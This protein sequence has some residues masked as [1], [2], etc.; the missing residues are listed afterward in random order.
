M[1]KFISKLAAGCPKTFLQ[2]LELARLEIEERRTIEQF[3]LDL[4]Q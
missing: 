4:E 3:G 2:T 1:V